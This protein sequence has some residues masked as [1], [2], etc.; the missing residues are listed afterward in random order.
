VKTRT[1]L[2]VSDLP[3]H[4]HGPQ[5]V[6]WW[7]TFGFM[8]I[9]GTGFAL[10]IAIYLYF[11]SLASEWPLSTPPPG[12]LW[13]TLITVWLLLSEVPNVMVYRAAHHHQVGKVRLLIL[14]MTVAGIVPL[15]L[16][17]YEFK[18]LWTMWDSNAYGSTVWVLLGLH[19]THLVTDLGDTIVLGA[20]MFTR[21]GHNKRRLG[22]V[23]DNAL[24][25]HFVVLAWLPIYFVIYWVPRL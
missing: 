16:R 22:D 18:T 8:L 1:V 5:S 14:V 10:V 6:T 9:E 20:M 17:W 12:L 23:Q 21:H 15:V 7:G 13:G 4:G 19:A 2:D 11:R 25:W 3:L 24:Y